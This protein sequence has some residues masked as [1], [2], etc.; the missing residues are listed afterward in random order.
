MKL[1]FESWIEMNHYSSDSMKLFKSSLECYRA[2]VYPASLLM[3]YLGFII[4]LK[5]RI[6]EAQ[7]PSGFPEQIWRNMIKGLQNEDLWEV[8]VVN[9]ILRQEITQ[10]PKGG[11]PVFPINDNIRNQIR[12]W[13]DRRNDCAHNKD[14]EINISHVESFWAFLES[15]LQKITIEGG[16]ITLINKFKRYFDRSYTSATQDIMPLIMEITNSVSKGELNSF[17][18]ELFEAVS[19]LFD[20]SIEILLIKKVF[21]FNNAVLTDSLI[22]H[23]KTD[24]SLMKDLL[25]KEPYFF[26]R[27]EFS[28]EETRNFWQKKLNN[29]SNGLAVF[30]SMLRNNLIPEE[31]IK[32]A[33]EKMVLFER[34]PDDYEDHNTLLLSGFGNALYEYLFITHSKEQRTYWKFMNAKARLFITYIEKYPLKKETV[35]ILCEELG[36]EEWT[37]FFLKEQLENLFSSNLFKMNEF[38]DIATR[39]GATLPKKIEILHD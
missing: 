11:P 8:S 31:E 9:A 13:K 38:T 25:N 7:M 17:W 34:Y 27:L 36:K 20:Y 14:N 39:I 29:M 30:A 28:R 33:C 4:V 23:I 6:M 37:S 10:G 18:K 35:I 1:K 24:K 5:D 12:Y 2:Q 21:K 15:N 26:Q 22:F 16:K 32:E 19:D 3:S